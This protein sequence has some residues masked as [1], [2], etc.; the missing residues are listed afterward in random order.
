[1]PTHA[2]AEARTV[3]VTGRGTATVVPDVAVVAVAAAHVAPSMVDALAGA[4]S[5]RAAVVA[6]VVA[7]APGASAASR[8]VSVWQDREAGGFHAE[9][10]VVVRCADLAQAGALLGSLA[11]EVGDRLRI[12]DVRLTVSDTDAAEETARSAAYADARARAEHLAG[13]AGGALG[14]VLSVTDG[15]GSAGEA[16]AYARAAAD[17]VL[18]PGE[19]SVGCALTV[20]FE[21]TRQR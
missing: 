9:H 18:E 11:R 1:M 7:D 19:Q 8:G 15:G 12:D 5:A 2:S 13:L 14:E 17:V 16:R 3:T 20:T 21:L 4:E 10:R 6:T